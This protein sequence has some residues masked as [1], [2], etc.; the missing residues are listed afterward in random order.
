MEMCLKDGGGP[1][2]SFDSSIKIPRLK[3]QF[4][5]HQNANLP[6]RKMFPPL[7]W[8]LPRRYVGQ[9]QIIIDRQVGL[10][11]RCCFISIKP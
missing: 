2:K 8:P 5:F 11:T 1:H 9:R 3:F 4:I 10:L 7:Y 6:C